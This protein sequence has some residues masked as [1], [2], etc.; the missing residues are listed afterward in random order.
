[1]WSLRELKDAGV[2]LTNYSTPCLFAA[3]EAMEHTLLTLQSND[4]LLK[5]RDGERVGVQGCTAILNENLSR[6]DKH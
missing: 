5:N 1:M 6:R 3:Q 2:S 4:G